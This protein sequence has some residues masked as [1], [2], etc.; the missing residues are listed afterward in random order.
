MNFFLW[1]SQKNKTRSR[2]TS[3]YSHLNDQGFDSADDSADDD[4][5]IIYLL[6]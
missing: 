2:L 6:V 3:V 5:G 4:F 1:E